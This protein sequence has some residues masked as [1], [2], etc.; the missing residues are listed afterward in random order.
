MF[1]NDRGKISAVLN[2]VQEYSN[3]VMVSIANGS[4]QLLL[5]MFPGRLRIKESIVF[6]HHD[7]QNFLARI[8][9]TRVCSLLLLQ[10][11]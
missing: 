8:Q 4:N 10:V 9:F 3:H 7:I 11:I 6:Y 5:E 1:F 2:L